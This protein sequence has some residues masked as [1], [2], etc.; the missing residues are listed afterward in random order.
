[1]FNLSELI[2]GGCCGCEVEH[3]VPQTTCYSEYNQLN[4]NEEASFSVPYSETGE[5]ILDVY[6][7]QSSIYYIPASMFTFY[8]NLGYVDLNSCDV[9][10]IRKNTFKNAAHLGEIHLSW[11]KISALGADTFRGA[12]R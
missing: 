10:E 5:N 7:R 11:N 9:Q 6:F 1:V 12:F 4:S 3:R 2:D 8:T